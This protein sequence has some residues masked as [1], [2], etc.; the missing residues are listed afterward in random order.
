LSGIDLAGMD[1]SGRDLSG[2]TLRNA[3][4]RETRLVEARLGGADLQGATL[5]KADLSGAVLDEADLT[6]A[7]LE[8]ANLRGASL[9][10]A[11]LAGAGL[12]G[13]TLT[14]ADLRYVDLDELDDV[15]L[16]DTYR[17]CPAPDCREQERELGPGEETCPACDVTAASACPFCGEY[18]LGCAHCVLGWDDGCLRPWPLFGDWRGA[19]TPRLPANAPCADG[20]SASQ[21]EQAFG[22][23]APLLEAYADG[24]AE[25]PS[26]AELLELLADRLTTPLTRLEWSGGPS[27]W[28]GGSEGWAIVAR[29]RD[30]ARA[31]IGVFLD[32]LADGFEQL[33]AIAPES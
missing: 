21:L 19:P 20:W 23:L 7:D 11:T 12:A 28:V 26:D 25:A 22:D 8:D 5:T 29:E 10:W 9:R 15:D 17:L 27:R 1:L 6:G 24:L 13:A 16:T 2:A 30:R 31:E 18:A 3:N 33:G 4:L 14:D 32:R